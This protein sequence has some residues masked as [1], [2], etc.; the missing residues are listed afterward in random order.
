MSVTLRIPPGLADQLSRHLSQ[1]PDEQ[2]AFMITTWDGDVA[3][4]IGLRPVERP[5][6]HRSD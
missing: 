6:L 5:S 1:G 3:T 2:L 4:V